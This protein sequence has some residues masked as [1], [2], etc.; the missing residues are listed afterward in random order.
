MIN[1]ITCVNLGV[2]F[3]YLGREC[4]LH[5]WLGFDIILFVGSIPMN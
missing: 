1:E 4:I 2:Y 3:P 5:Q